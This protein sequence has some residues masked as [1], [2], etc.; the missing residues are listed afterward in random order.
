MLLLWALYWKCE[1]VF[2]GNTFF[3]FLVFLIPLILISILMYMQQNT[4]SFIMIRGQLVG[5]AFLLLTHGSKYQSQI[6]QQNICTHSSTLHDSYKSILDNKYLC[7]HTHTHTHTHIYIYIYM[8]V[9]VYTYMG[10]T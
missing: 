10:Y 4:F 3:Y 5:I 9:C 1:V 2:P 8:C 6:W 7:T